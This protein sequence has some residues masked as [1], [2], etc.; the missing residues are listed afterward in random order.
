MYADIIQLQESQ[1]IQLLNVSDVRDIHILLMKWQTEN[2]DKSIGDW[3]HITY[4]KFWKD[5][6][7]LLSLHYY[8]KVTGLQ[9]TTVQKSI[10]VV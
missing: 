2:Y 9:Y 6:I 5:L 10:G 8:N 3:L 4:K 1:I 7:R